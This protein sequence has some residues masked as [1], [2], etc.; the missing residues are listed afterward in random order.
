MSSAVP[1]TANYKLDHAHYRWLEELMVFWFLSPET[2][3]IHS[4][5]SV[6][7]VAPQI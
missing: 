7:Y 3:A 6:A 4:D 5:Y 2:F 1:F